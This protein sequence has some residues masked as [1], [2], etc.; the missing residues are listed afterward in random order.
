MKQLHVP[1]YYPIP[2]TF[3]GGALHAETKSDTTH[4]HQRGLQ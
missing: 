2:E 3:N 1:K 4:R